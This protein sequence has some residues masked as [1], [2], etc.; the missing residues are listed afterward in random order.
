MKIVKR[1]GQENCA[2]VYILEDSSG[3]LTEAVESFPEGNATQKYVLILSSLYGCPVKC[4]FCDASLHYQGKIS[5]ANL[6]AQIRLLVQQRFNSA[7]PQTA[8]FKVQFSRMGEPSFNPDVIK[9]IKSILE[10]YGP[11]TIISVST[12]APLRSEKFFRNLLQIKKQ[13]NYKKMQLQFSLHSTDETYRNMLIPVKKM[14]LAALSVLG[15]NFRLDETDKKVTLNFALTKNSPVDTNLLLKYFSPQ[16]FLIKITPVNPTCKSAQNGL[17]TLYQSE[18]DH[19]DIEDELRL[20]G[21]EV[22]VSIGNLEENRIGSNCGQY[23]QAMRDQAN[24]EQKTETEIY[25]NSL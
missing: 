21:Y 5:S 19:F 24:Y 7:F 13:L 6:L 10:N 8:K 11:E 1:F 20:A 23:L 3:I 12:I 16:D 17:N 9:A 25:Q 18:S 15:R 2:F 4:L 22:I 14:D